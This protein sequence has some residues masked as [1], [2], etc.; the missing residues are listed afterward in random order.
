MRNLFYLTLLIFI[1]S[2]LSYAQNFEWAQQNGGEGEDVVRSLVVD[3]EGNTY[4]TGYFTDVS[5]FGSEESETE[6][7]SNG[8]YDVFVAK[9]SP[10]GNL[11]W[12]KTF[13]GTGF[14]LGTGISIDEE[15]NVYVTGVFEETVNFNPEG[16]NS[17]TSA[18]QQDIFILKL[19]S[20]GSFNWVK[21]IG[22]TGYEET[23]SIGADSMGNV[24]ATG[25][26]YETVNFNPEGEVFEMTPQGSLSSDGFIVK[27][28]ENGDFIWAQKFGGE[29]MDLPME[30]KVM[31]NGDMH[32]TG[33]FEGMADFNPNP[34]ESSFLMTEE[35]F[36]GVFYL[37]LNNSG[38]LQQA[39]KVAEAPFEAIGMDLAIDNE[40]NVYITGNFG[41]TITFASTNGEDSFTFT[42]N[43]YYNGF[44]AKINLEG[45]T[46]WAKHIAPV[47]VEETSSM[48][49]GIAVNENQEAFLSGF[50]SNTVAFDEFE[51]TQQTDHYMTPYLAKI[52]ENGEFV[53]VTQ[54][55][56][57]NFIDNHFI[58][59][60]AESN[61]Y[62]SGTFEESGDLNPD[63]NGELISES[64]G[65]RDLYVIKMNNEAMSVSDPA[66]E[67]SF[68]V[69]P[70]P[71]YG[72]FH[73]T[74][75]KDL[76]GKKYGIYDMSGREITSGVMD[77]DS[78][79]EL[80]HLNK[81]VY[82]L[83]IENQTF[84]LIKK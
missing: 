69:Y 84:Q 83:K 4:I 72:I 47:T 51:L 21:P 13:G 6:I 33:N 1:T 66:P 38:Y 12:I 75:D 60:D 71:S 8:W 58:G 44:A 70:N 3:P 36:K 65:F 31:E 37:Y 79:L 41:G 14:D 35:D 5:Y 68:S 78:T 81:G 50:F 49:Y 67:T 2:H 76:S 40:S 15:K 10:E 16:E 19:S 63:P 20:D 26:F 28:A 11:V 77:K 7:V 57:A 62:L 32:L 17:M 27:Y 61:I 39:V 29:G 9:T 18:G 59:T 43:N 74:S 56:G 25:Y 23:T 52:N 55:A 42:S 54:F 80:S 48:G 22:G 73:I 82:V 24:Y 45:N 34:S 30:M 53:F 46:L 64:R